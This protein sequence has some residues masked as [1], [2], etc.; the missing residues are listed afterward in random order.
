MFGEG[1]KENESSKDNVVVTSLVAKFQGRH[2]ASPTSSLELIVS[3]R[4]GPKA[5]ATSKV[6]I[7]TFWEDVLV[8]SLYISKKYLDYDKKLDEAQS[9]I[10]S[11]FAKNESLTIQ[12][13]LLLTR[14]RKRKI[15]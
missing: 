1:E 15:V 4:G 2:T 6:S 12:F 14:P 8:E 13:P 9:G 10:A 3:S 5:K 11:L 7:A